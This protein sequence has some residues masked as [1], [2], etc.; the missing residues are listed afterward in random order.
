L[1]EAIGAYAGLDPPAWLLEARVRER[2][3]EL[4]LDEQSY[5]ERV[6]ADARERA[7]LL[8][9]LRVGE[10]RFFRHRAQIEALRSRILPSLFAEG[11][12]VRCWS[13]GCATG[14][15]AFTLAMLC[16]EAA[17]R[18]DW[19]V[20]GTDLSA[21]AI[22]SA[23]SGEFPSRK[24]EEVPEQYRHRFVVQGDKMRIREARVRF[25]RQNLVEPLSPRAVDVLLCRNVL[26]YFDAERRAQV[27][28][29][30]GEA[31][32][33][34]GWLFLGYSEMLRPGE[35]ARLEPVRVGECALYRRREITARIELPIDE[36]GPEPPPQKPPTKIEQ[37]AL[38]LLKLRGEYT[39]GAR[40]AA[41][42]RP[43]LAEAAIVD[44]DGAHFL[45]DEAARVLQRARQ[46]APHLVLRA[47]RAPII[48]WLNKHGLLR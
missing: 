16:H 42:L 8:E 19:E 47:T 4:G 32:R 6:A 29:R 34:G 3:D 48:R 44:L 28:A 22:A 25:S 37:P 27:I 21:A 40:L 11:R 36:E 24:L 33:T 7:H 38:P 10:T 9:R 17:P 23:E 18:G 41:E 35:D 14:E 2:A 12:L 26:I 20:L 43:F 45:G 15:E 13:A 46:A 31:L 39:D 30:L 5:V 1:A